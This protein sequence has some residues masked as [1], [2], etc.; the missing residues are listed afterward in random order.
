MT[1]AGVNFIHLSLGMMDQLLTSSYELAVMDNE[2]LAAAFRLGEGIQ[3]NPETLALDQI[4]QV[5]IGGH[6]LNHDF[7]LYNYRRHQWQPTLT[8]RLG[9]EEW[10]R[11]YGGKNMRQRANELARKLLSEHHPVV[12]S[13]AQ[14]RELDRM[15][16]AFQQQA[17][18]TS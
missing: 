18:K 8:T 10:Q 5:G 2:I 11:L 1:L 4:R 16:S 6:F 7:T 9:W 14:V 12:L 3:I 15:A 17:L 13:D